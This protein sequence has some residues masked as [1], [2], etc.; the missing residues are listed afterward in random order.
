MGNSLRFITHMGSKI[1]IPITKLT[2]TAL[3]KTRGRNQLD[4]AG[5][6]GPSRG[7]LFVAKQGQMFVKFEVNLVDLVAEAL[8]KTLPQLKLD[9]L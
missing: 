9:E 1:E 3:S 5:E 2:C 6:A 8:S 7:L 4:I